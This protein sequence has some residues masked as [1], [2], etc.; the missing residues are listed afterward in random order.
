MTKIAF[1]ARQNSEND[2]IE[3][4]KKLVHKLNFHH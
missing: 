2:H 3:T 1:P 4:H